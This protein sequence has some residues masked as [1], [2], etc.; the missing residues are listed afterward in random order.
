M[1]RILLLT[2]ACLL[3]FSTGYA[4]SA[5]WQ[6]ARE[7]D[8]TAAKA[9][10]ESFPKKY[11]LYK[12]DLAVLQ[13]ALSIAPLRGNGQTSDIII[14]LPDGD[15]SLQHF[16]IFKAPVIAPG[17]EAKHPGIQSYIGQGIEKKSSVVRFSTTLFGL[18]AMT[19]TAGNGTHYID[20]YTKDGSYYIVYKKSELQTAKTFKC[21][22]EN[23]THD[24]VSTKDNAMPI[25]TL[26]NGNLRTYRLAI[27]TTVEYSAFHIAEAGLEAAPNNEK[28][29]AV[30]S[31][32]AVTITR[33][34][35][36]YERD[37]SVSLQLIENNDQLVFI[38]TD[39]LNNDDAGA[40]LNE[41]NA[42]M[43]DVIGTDNF[44]MGH[45]FGTGGG[46]LAAG[47]PCS[48]FKGGAMTGIGS[49]VGDPFDIDYVAHE[50]GHQ[51][52]AGHTFNAECGG[53]R[54]AEQAYEPGGG[55]TILAYA[56]VCDPVIQS[57]SDAQLHAISIKQMRNKI[58][59][60]SNCVPL[61]NSG[62]TPPVANAGSDYTIPKGT[63]FILEGKAVDVD[64]DGLTY[65]WEQ[66]NNEISVQPP[67]PEAIGGPNFRSLPISESPNRFMPKIEDVIAGN[68]APQW[69]VIPTV[70]RA[71]DF[72]L[73]V[74]DNNINGGE[75]HT[76]YMHIQVSGGAGPF[77]V[78]SPDFEITWQAGTNKNVT[79]NVAGT[80]ANG[81]NTPYVDIYL[82]A[83][84][85][86][87]Y[88]T[89][90]ALKV[91]NDGTETIIVPNIPGESNR[92]MVRGHN[93][94][95]YDISN[96]NFTITA[97]QEDA[98]LTTVNGKWTTAACKGT[99][100]TFNL[101]YQEV[102][103]ASTPTTTFT[104][105][106]NPQ[107]SIVTFSPESINGDGIVAVAISNTTEDAP[108]LYT[109]VVTMTSGN[110]VKT[111]N[112]YLDLLSPE[113]NTLA[114]L[115]PQNT[116][117]GQPSTVTFSWNP[118]PNATMY[119]LQVATDDAFATIISN[120][121]TTASSYTV[122]GLEE[123]KNYYWRVK[124]QNEGCTGNFT[125]GF[126]FTTGAGFCNAY[127]SA[128]VPLEISGGDPSTI[129]S[130][131]TVTDDFTIVDANLSLTIEHS[132]IADVV[133]KLISPA[134]TSVLL[135]GGACG[136]QDGAAATFDDSGSIL[137]CSSSAPAISGTV[138]PAEP[139]SAFNGQTSAGIWKL[140]ISDTEGGD[141][142]V[143]N[144]WSLELCGVSEVLGVV[145][146]T[147]SDFMIYPNP[148]N[149]SFMVQFDADAG[150][151]VNIDVYDVSGRRIYNNKTI[152]SGGLFAEAI[153][154]T[155]QAGMYLVEVEQSGKK[156]SKKIV[157]K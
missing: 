17:L 40:L 107:G 18:H 148:S 81:V 110:T 51:F 59:S 139:L 41:G 52:G 147:T 94:I 120:A 150:E 46:G 104:A 62:N 143:I 79:W 141:G 26:D 49:P 151:A 96:A 7:A 19:L 54:S 58:N 154:L 90:L 31:A 20:P 152:A 157:I 73:T 145:K 136:D 44:D 13:S 57:N 27:V 117:L 137:S 123:V 113:F 103:A 24:N 118:D 99:D 122:T 155:A 89:L 32:I 149:G 25:T 128:D 112:L 8:I 67:V 28:M 42:V 43:Y 93:N 45:S 88:P 87:T 65:N 127:A 115:S 140:E 9:A 125:D 30:L 97:P 138:I 66:M 80:T 64:N 68:L 124:A 119:E 48:D 106:G 2:A 63:A 78:T 156:S 50:M 35:S 82:S 109:I 135:F 1:K 153:R 15:G 133:V 34:N 38:D 84:G 130:E 5:L 16:R 85:G 6:T 3:F 23:I 102:N 100:V 74:R 144:S 98:S 121:T 39:E 76:D 77:M 4:Q 21:L 70:A 142:G 12:L 33:V 56:G 29:E 72:A 108:G 10:R 129:N 86:F 69:E 53:N 131:V 114:L 75:S 105:T 116:A 111:Q 134:G 126:R 60:D 91:P 92:I 95:F 146:N 14:S 132:W 101:S 11:Q 36:M 55:S 71:M 61:V 22:T 83:D 37:L 47:S